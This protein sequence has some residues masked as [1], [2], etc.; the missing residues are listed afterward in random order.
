MEIRSTFSLTNLPA[1]LC[2]ELGSSGDVSLDFSA[3][4]SGGE[5]PDTITWSVSAP[6]GS[7]D[8]Y[9]SELEFTETYT[10]E[11]LYTYTVRI[12]DANGEWAEDIRVVRVAISCEVIASIVSPADESTFE[13]GDE[14]TFEGLAFG[15]LPPYTYQWN[16][17]Q[18]SGLP[19]ST[20]LDPGVSYNAAGE[21][22]VTL[23]VTDSNGD[24]DVASI[25][26][27]ITD[28]QASDCATDPGNPEISAIDGNDVT[29][30]W[31]PSG[32]ISWEVAYSPAGGEE[33]IVETTETQVTLTGLLECTSLR[34]NGAGLL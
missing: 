23:T 13:V 21:Y 3:T 27:T 28:D 24:T 31:E 2:I 33:E 4:V 32:H 9:S 11:G 34:D 5:P 25:S 10:Q 14:I 17:G 30:V 15:G 19:A 12:E 20:E 16:F 26:I 22:D 8:D 7:D 29:I 18:D 1:D 6:D